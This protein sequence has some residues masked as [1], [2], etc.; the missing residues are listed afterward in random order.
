M[1]SNQT[2]KGR[3]SERIAFNV[4]N[5]KDGHFK[6]FATNNAPKLTT[7]ASEVELKMNTTVLSF[8]P[9]DVDVVRDVANG[10]I[11]VSTPKSAFFCQLHGLP[12]IGTHTTVA[13]KD[14]FKVEDDEEIF[15]EFLKKQLIIRD[16]FE[17]L[18]ENNY[19]TILLIIY[20][21]RQYF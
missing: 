9:D 11:C 7:Y 20:I 1:T 6:W 15:R 14:T 3:Y 13:I 2:N 17:I 10:T 21:L 8:G 5:G 18:V 16:W 12:N 19:F 4:G